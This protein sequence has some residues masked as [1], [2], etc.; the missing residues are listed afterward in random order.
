MKKRS[1]NKV[2]TGSMADIAFLLL[3]FWLMTTSLTE[4]KGILRDLPELDQT[5]ESNVIADEK[6]LNV[7]LNLTNDLLVENEEIEID[8]LK[9]LAKEF[10]QNGGVFK[11]EKPNTNFIERKWIRAEDI[12]MKIE[13][14]E[15]QI[16]EDKNMVNLSLK[17]QLSLYKKQQMAISYFGEFKVLDSDAIISIQHDK[18][19]T[20]EQYVQVQN[21]LSSAINE[22]RDELSLEHFGLSYS[23]LLEE[24]RRNELVAVMQVYPQ[25]ISEAE[26]KNAIK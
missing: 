8:Q 10:L 19:S 9:A 15:K 14:I 21:E 1:L 16:Q 25:R 24:D 26:F 23:K 11:D 6:V 20:Y 13:L 5:N 4:E 17:G 7:Y 2:H 12:E 18:A 3:V 22:L